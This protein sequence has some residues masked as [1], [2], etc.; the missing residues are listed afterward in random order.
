MTMPP[1]EPKIISV[2]PT[3]QALIGALCDADLPVEDLEASKASFYGIQAAGTLAGFGGIQVLGRNCLLRSLVILP[4]HQRRGL[5]QMLVA[6]L[7]ETAARQNLD[8]AYLLTTTAPDFF[9]SL[10][11]TQISRAMAPPKI[12]YTAK[13]S[14][15]C[16]GDALV[17]YRDLQPNV[18]S[19]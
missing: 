1:P 4:S 8:A 15:L 18:G 6:K 9:A 14:S 5:G 13:F 16:P 10:G 11:F 19:F 3:D 12:R 7:L 2:A 17:M